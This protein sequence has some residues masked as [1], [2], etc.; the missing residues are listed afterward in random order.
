MCRGVLHHWTT[1][2]SKEEVALVQDTYVEVLK[3]KH[4]ELEAELSEENQRPLPD[5]ATTQSL[6]R[7]KLLIKDELARLEAA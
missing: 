6:K 1:T 3:A 5:A 7:R 2:G 4:R